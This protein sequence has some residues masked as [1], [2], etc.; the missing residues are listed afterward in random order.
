M[1]SSA[2]YKQQQKRKKINQFVS[3]ISNFDARSDENLNYLNSILGPLKSNHELYQRLDNES[4]EAIKAC[5]DT[6]ESSGQISHQIIF[7]ID[8]KVFIESIDIYE[9]SCDNAS[10]FKIEAKE[11]KPNKVKDVIQTLKNNFI[12]LHSFNFS[13]VLKKSVCSF[14]L[15]IHLLYLTLV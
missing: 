1:A 7:K 3:K 14:R 2:T 8:E 11:I 12:E 5:G 4:F 15:V 6:I 9:K 13:I 10:L